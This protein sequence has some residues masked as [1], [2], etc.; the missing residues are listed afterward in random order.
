ME[1]AALNVLARLFRW[2]MIFS[3]NGLRHDSNQP[4]AIRFDPRGPDLSLAAAV[5][6]SCGRSQR[7][8]RRRRTDEVG[9]ALDRSRDLR[10]F[11]IGDGCQ[12][13]DRIRQ[14]HDGA[15][16]RRAPAG[17]EIVADRHAGDD[18]I[19]LGADDDDPQEIGEW[20]LP[21][22]DFVQRRHAA[23]PLRMIETTYVTAASRA[24]RP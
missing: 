23:T 5:N 11:Q 8:S 9:L 17:A 3:E 15:A 6:R 2:S 22:V 12:R 24:T 13:A 19:Q 4:A 21:G 18:A 1:T 7:R 20:N 16:M 10:L 14:G